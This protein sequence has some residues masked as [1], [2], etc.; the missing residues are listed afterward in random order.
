[1]GMEGSTVT[2][3]DKGVSGN[4]WATTLMSPCLALCPPLSPLR[5]LYSDWSRRPHDAGGFPG[6][7]RGCARVPVHAGTGEYPFCAPTPA[8]DSLPPKFHRTDGG[9]N[10]APQG[11]ELASA[12]QG[13]S[14]PGLPQ[15]PSR[16]VDSSPSSVVKP[17]SSSSLD[18]VSSHLPKATKC[19]DFVHLFFPL[20][21]QV[22]SLSLVAKICCNFPQTPESIHFLLLQ[23]CDFCE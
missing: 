9:V 19:Q 6:L 16:T 13:A 20:N 14:M 4:S 21:P 1:M 18:S 17:S 12:P 3:R 15:L 8:P 7:L 10:G 22:H 5:S 11:H 23:I 2:Q